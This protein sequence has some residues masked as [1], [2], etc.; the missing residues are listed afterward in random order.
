[1]RLFNGHCT[2]QYDDATTT[3]TATRNTTY[4]DDNKK[5]HRSYNDMNIK[6][7]LKN[8]NKCEYRVWYLMVRHYCF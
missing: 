7:I 8:K 1:M 5:Y 6:E 2:V 3:A 4:Y